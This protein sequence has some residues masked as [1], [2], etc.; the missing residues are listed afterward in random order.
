MPK[1]HRC[2][3]VGGTPGGSDALHFSGDPAADADGDGLSAL[4]E[5]ALGS[6]DSDSTS[7][8]D[9]TSSGSVEIGGA[10]YA[11]FSYQ[12]NL[13]AEDVNRSVESSGDLETWTDADA[14]LVELSS[15]VNPDG[16]VTKTLRLATPLTDDSKQYFRLRVEL[17]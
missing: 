9:A 16:T 6:S 12:S 15:V 5:Y 4:V 10:S 11:T 8:A 17:R 3:A 7:G 14:Q 13:A 1:L 2:A